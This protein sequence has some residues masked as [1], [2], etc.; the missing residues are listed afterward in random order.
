MLETVAALDNVEAII[1]VDVVDMLLV[2]SNDLCAEMGT[3][4]QFDHPRQKGAFARSIAAARAIGKHVG[5]GGLAVRDDLVAQF[6]GM[7]R[8]ICVDRTDLISLLA[9]SEQRARFVWEIGV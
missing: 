3:A 1:A 5:I 2:G 9:A 8:T 4:G 7:G 6:V